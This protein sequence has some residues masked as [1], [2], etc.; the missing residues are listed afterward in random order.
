M[1]DR[2]PDAHEASEI[3]RLPRRA[4]LWWL[5]ILLPLAAFAAAATV[6]AMNSYRLADEE[7][8]TSTARA[9]AAAV[10][11]RLAEKITALKVLADSRRLN[12]EVSPV[13]FEDRMN[14]VGDHLNG[15]LSLLGSP[16]DL[17][18][19]AM[20]HSLPGIELPAP[21]LPW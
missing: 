8:L 1:R 13:A 5:L 14:S 21:F 20:S 3:A 4:F 17:R 18:V 10:D 7:R 6:S 19:L 15:R 9:L 2:K 16:P 12:G 11:A